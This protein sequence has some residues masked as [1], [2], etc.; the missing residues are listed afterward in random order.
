MSYGHPRRLCRGVHNWWRGAP[1]EAFRGAVRR[2]CGRK[3]RII[4]HP[5]RCGRGCLEGTG[6]DVY[7]GF[8][9][10]KLLYAQGVDGGS[11][12]G[13]ADCV[14]EGQSSAESVVFGG[15][16]GHPDVGGEEFHGAADSSGMCFGYI[17]CVTTIMFWGR[18]D[19]PA[20]DSVGW[21]SCAR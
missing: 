6:E 12:H 10:G 20:V 14:E 19:I 1:G 15:G 11:R 8:Q 21:V 13:V 9:R 2:G 4:R 7:Q 18:S 16:A 3:V 5:R 17:Y